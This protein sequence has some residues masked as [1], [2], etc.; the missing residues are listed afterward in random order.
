MPKKWLEIVGN[1]FCSFAL[2]L[3]SWRRYQSFSASSLTSLSGAASIFSYPLTFFCL[4]LG[5]RL[6]LL[7]HRGEQTEQREVR[8]RRRRSGGLFARRFTLFLIYL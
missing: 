3:K 7:L 4:D 2:S 8:P 5:N 1:R 6:Y